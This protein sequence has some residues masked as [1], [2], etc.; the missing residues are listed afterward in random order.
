MCF[1]IWVPHV[2]VFTCP[3]LSLSTCGSACFLGLC[4]YSFLPC[5]HLSHI[6][7]FPLS[8]HAFVSPHLFVSMSMCSSFHVCMFLW[9]CFLCLHVSISAYFHV[10]V[11]PI[12]CMF[13]HLLFPCLCA[14]TSGWIQFLCFCICICFYIC[15]FMSVYSCTFEHA[16]VGEYYLEAT[17]EELMLLNCGVGEESWE[18]LGL[19]GDPTSPS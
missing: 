10:Y 13:P 1:C 17:W 15:I 11:F 12:V 7:T 19:Q 8:F 2:C 9:E 16:S 14:F 18:S 5:L 4:F 6:F 3:Y